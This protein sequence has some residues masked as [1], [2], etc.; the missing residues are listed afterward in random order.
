MVENGLTLEVQGHTIH[1]GLRT[2]KSR[3][4]RAV[5]VDQEDVVIARQQRVESGVRAEP[6]NSPI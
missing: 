4:V 1:D 3:E 2:V 6:G 5:T